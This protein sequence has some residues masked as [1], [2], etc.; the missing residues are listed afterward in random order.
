MC[1]SSTR[2]SLW[3]LISVKDQMMQFFEMVA[4]QFE[5]VCDLCNGRLDNVN[6]NP[7]FEGY[8]RIF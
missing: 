6:G 4:Y 2:I 3:V 1:P 5:L 8:L 7:G